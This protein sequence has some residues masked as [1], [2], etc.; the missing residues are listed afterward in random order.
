MKLLHEAMFPHESCFYEAEEHLE[1]GVK[2]KS[3]KCPLNTSRGNIF[4]LYLFIR[5]SWKLFAE[6]YLKLVNFIMKLDLYFITDSGFGRKHEDLAEIALKA[7]IRIIQFR[8]KK[9]ST[10]NMFF[11]AKKIRKLTREY[12]ATFIVNDRVDL[13]LAVDADGVHIGQDDLPVEA[14]RDIFNGIIGVSTHNVEEAKNAEK[15]A[16]YIS[17]GPVFYTKTKRDAGKPIGIDGLRRIVESVRI[18]VVAIG[19]INRENILDVLKTGVEGV[20]VISAIA[21]SKDPENAAREL[22]D[23]VL[24]FKKSRI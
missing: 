17:A 23:I 10:R 4:N 5:D 7:G 3:I 15:Y 1:Y 2:I 24:R 12:G 19:G 6:I 20:A 13:A 18:P 14:V 11:T 22:L 21:C 16:D 8:E 9:M